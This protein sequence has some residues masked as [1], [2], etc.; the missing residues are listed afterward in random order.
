MAFAPANDPAKLLD[1]DDFFPRRILPRL[2]PGAGKRGRQFKGRMV[3][4]ESKSRIV[5]GEC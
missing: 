2:G 4:A 5:R 1:G 3:R